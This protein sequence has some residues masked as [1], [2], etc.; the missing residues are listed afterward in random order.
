M[1]NKVQKIKKFKKYFTNKKYR[2]IISNKLNILTVD[3]FK[4]KNKYRSGIYLSQ[5][6]ENI[7]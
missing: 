4:S 7:I 2:A 1:K 3:Y 5:I 6:F